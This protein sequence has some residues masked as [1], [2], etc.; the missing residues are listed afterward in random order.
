M[1]TLLILATA[2]AAS[3]VGACATNGGQ[4]AAL[5]SAT[6]DSSLE[7]LLFAW[8]GPDSI[9]VRVAS[10]GCTDADSFD[11]AVEPEPG[12]QG[13]YRLAIK[14]VERDSC[15]GYKPEGERVEFSRVELGVPAEAAV[16]FAN[17]VGR[18]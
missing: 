7:R 3:L 5:Q 16:T 15:R 9:Q 14:R 11:V 13:A 8:A 18:S 2:A 12:A 10:N 6:V 17:P 4:S 1:R